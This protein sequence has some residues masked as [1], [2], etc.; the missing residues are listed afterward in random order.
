LKASRIDLAEPAF[1]SV[2]FWYLRNYSGP[3]ALRQSSSSC[4]AAGS[5]P[6]VGASFARAMAAQS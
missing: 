4:R 2:K 6:T 3:L 5:A 1:D